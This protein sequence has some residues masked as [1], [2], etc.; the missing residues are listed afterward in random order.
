MNSYE[1]A[2]FDES[3]FLKLFSSVLILLKDGMENAIVNDRLEKKLYDYRDDEQYIP[4]FDNMTFKGNKLNLKPGFEQL[5]NE[6]LLEPLDN[7][8]S[9]IKIDNDTA[10]EIL[11]LYDDSKVILM[12]R[13]VTNMYIS[14]NGKVKVKSNLKK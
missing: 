2:K 3:D 8:S 10:L 5:Y 1:N 13:L 14:N 7:T 11:P 6:K 12:T 9:L 4:I